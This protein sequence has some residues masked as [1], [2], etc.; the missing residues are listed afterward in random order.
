MRCQNCKRELGDGLLPARCPHCGQSPLKTNPKNE[1]AARKNL[2]DIV[3][4]TRIAQ[5]KR[6]APQQAARAS[7]TAKNTAENSKKR[8]K[9]MIIGF[10]AVAGAVFIIA[11]ISFI[12]FGP[13]VPDVVG[14]QADRAKTTLEQTGYTVERT[15]EFSQTID[16]DHVV[17]TDPSALAFCPEGSSVKMAVAKARIMPDIVGKMK[18]E[19]TAACDAQ[20][21]PYNLKEEASDKP[22]GTIIS[23]SLAAGST[24]EANTS[25]VLTVAI[26]LRIPHV[27]GLTQA[28]AESALRA[29]SLDVVVQYRHSDDLAEQGKVL[30]SDPVEGTAV[31]ANSKVTLV[32]ASSTQ[33]A[34]QETAEAV[35]NAIYGQTPAGDSIGAILLPYLSASCPYATASPHD[36]WWGLVKRGGL[37]KN[38]NPALQSLPRVIVSKNI[39]VAADGKSATA[40]VVVRWDWTPM[41]AKY[42]GVTSQDTHNIQMTFDDQGK[43]VGFYDPATDIPAFT[44]G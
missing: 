9:M 44:Y 6:E 24:V 32:V 21:I 42:A 16:A 41:G 1:T 34:A 28:E 10:G 5:M 31:S 20:S 18:D 12:G 30:S 23:S 14:W 25:A 19:A 8:A 11:L 39:E 33:G 2:R 13:H 38:E 3:S 27:V 35:I 4:H 29:L 17:S 36:V 26:P 43:L 37:Y 15:E 7:R 40:S 22:E